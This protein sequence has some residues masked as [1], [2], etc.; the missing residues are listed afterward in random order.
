MP[1]TIE[2][3]S[4]PNF[5]DP[6]IQEVLELSA[7]AA[8]SQAVANV[9]NPNNVNDAD[10]LVLNPGEENGELRKINT[11]GVT[12]NAITFTSNL[13]LQHRNHERILK[14]TGNKIRVYRAPNVDGTPP[15]ASAFSLLGTVTIDPDQ[16]F[17]YYVDN[18][19]GA[20][21]WYLFTYFNDVSSFET[22][23]GLAEPIRGGGYGHY[24]TLGDL[25][26]EAGLNETRRLD[27]T[28]VAQRRV[29]AESEVKGALAAAGYI[30]PLQTA[31][32]AYFTPAVVI[33]TVRVLGAGLI[34]SQNFGVTKP[35]SAKDGKAKCDSARATL[36]RITGDKIVLL[37]SN[38]QPLLKRNLIDGWPDDTTATIG[39]DGRTPEPAKAS[40]SKIF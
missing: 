39:S 18:A 36:D 16:P 32:G 30:M 15:S 24:V 7:D 27:D 21:F 19:G 20:G 13:S 29:E 33:G 11:S 38:D 37:D 17:S 9:I 1:T 34:V 35:G 23:L 4:L 3:I 10:Y 8:P 12:G 26:A 25:R 22:D 40:M 28:Q 31:N 14:L 5:L 6:N 2:T